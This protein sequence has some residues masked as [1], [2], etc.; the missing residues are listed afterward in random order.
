MPIETDNLKLFMFFF[1]I[2]FYF[3]LKIIRSLNQS[4]IREFEYFS[5]VKG[6][7]C[8]SMYIVLFLV[9]YDFSICQTSLLLFLLLKHTHT[10]NLIYINLKLSLIS[11]FFRNRNENDSIII[12]YISQTYNLVYSICFSVFLFSVF[13]FYFLYRKTITFIKI[14]I[15]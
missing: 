2:F 5:K 15:F 3:F 9:F 4:L 11:I 8:Q 14:Y 10:F 13:F 12:N 6:F 1:S 7:R